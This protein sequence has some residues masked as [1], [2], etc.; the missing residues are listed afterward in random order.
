[1]QVFRL[2]VIQFALFGGAVAS[3]ENF[4]SC[5]ANPFFSLRMISLNIF[6]ECG[7]GLE[8]E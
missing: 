7:F 4:C 6:V 2:L 5:V 3:Y 1:M 8:S